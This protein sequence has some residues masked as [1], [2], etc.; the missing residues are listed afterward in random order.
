[1]KPRKVKLP[2]KVVRVAAKF[3][4]SFECG[5]GVNPPGWY[6]WEQGSFGKTLKRFPDLPFNREYSREVLEAR[7]YLVECR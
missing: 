1:M 3:D 5:T 4:H 7:G 6:V 2:D